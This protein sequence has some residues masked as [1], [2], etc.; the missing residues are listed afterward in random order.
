M[1]VTKTQRSYGH[2][3]GA[4]VAGILMILGGIREAPLRGP[5][6]TLLL[7]LQKV[8][9]LRGSTSPRVPDPNY[10]MTRLLAVGV[11]HSIS[12]FHIFMKFCNPSPAMQ[13]VLDI[14]EGATGKGDGWR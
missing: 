10:Y 5:F 1:G 2:K 13:D 7:A 9:L 3:A 11:L 4:P 8:T 14:G 6:L 12:R